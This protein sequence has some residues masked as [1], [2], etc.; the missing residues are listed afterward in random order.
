MGTE[1]SKEVIKKKKALHGQWYQ[2]FEI[3]RT[4]VPTSALEYNQEVK[5]VH[6]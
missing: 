3:L 2:I 4:S 6:S 5:A 1:N